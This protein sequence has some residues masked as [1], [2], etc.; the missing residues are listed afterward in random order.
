MPESTLRHELSGYRPSN[1]KAKTLVN[2]LFTD[3]EEAVFVNAIHIAQ[4][5]GLPFTV[6]N[7]LRA[8]EYIIDE[9]L[10]EN[11]LNWHHKGNCLTPCSMLLCNL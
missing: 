4:I 1:Y 6:D 11:S 5:R 7:I 3:E 10:K 8:V 2:R 9:D